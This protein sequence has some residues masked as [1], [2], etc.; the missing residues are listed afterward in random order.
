MSNENT[1]KAWIEG[2]LPEEHLRLAAQIV[3][4][5]MYV[6]TNVLAIVD[7]AKA[8][9]L[10]ESRLLKREVERSVERI[11]KFLGF[12]LYNEIQRAHHINAEV[13]KKNNLPFYSDA[14]VLKEKNEEVKKQLM[15]EL[16]LLKKTAAEKE[17]KQ[18]NLDAL[19]SANQEKQKNLDEKKKEAMVDKVTKRRKYYFS[20]LQ[21][22][23]KNN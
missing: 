20:Y 2:T 13:F 19:N 15:D 7:P 6:R 22:I 4:E 10:N 5:F 12:N 14:H 16:T 1:V 8:K 17:D 18:K 11:F 9:L 3:R 23:T 21:R